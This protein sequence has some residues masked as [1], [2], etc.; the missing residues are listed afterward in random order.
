MRPSRKS[1]RKQT[2]A[3]RRPPTSWCARKKAVPARR[4]SVWHRERRFSSG[5]IVDCSGVLDALNKSAERASEHPSE[6]GLDISPTLRQTLQHGNR[7][8]GDASLRPQALQAACRSRRRHRAGHP[9]H[10]GGCA[11]AAGDRHGRPQRSACLLAQRM[12]ADRPEPGRLSRPFHP[13]R[14]VA[15]RRRQYRRPAAPRI[16]QDS[17]LHGA[18]H[19][20]FQAGPPRTGSAGAVAAGQRG[21]ATGPWRAAPRHLSPQPAGLR[22]PP[23][24]HRPHRPPRQRTQDQARY[25]RILASC[26]RSADASKPPRA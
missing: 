22:Q 10:R 19:L 11:Y 17:R 26:C 6:P 9:L 3:R 25:T 1:R 2:R 14:Q 13:G 8:P 16:Q 20:E 5:F 15:G 7:Q 21:S 4:C 23:G 12:V 18:P 24:D